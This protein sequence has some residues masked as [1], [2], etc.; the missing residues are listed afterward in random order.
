MMAQPQGPHT[1]T[2][3]LSH[4]AHERLTRHFR[5]SALMAGHKQTEGSG[6]TLPPTEAFVLIILNA[7]AAGA[8]RV[9]IKSQ[10]AAGDTR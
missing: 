2:L 10:E 6:G 1:I 5:I 3:V 8:T 7:I 9:E 4:E